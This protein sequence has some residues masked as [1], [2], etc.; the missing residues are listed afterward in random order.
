MNR[1]LPVAPILAVVTTITLQSQPVFALERS[2]I[3]AKAKE[4]TVLINGEATGTG[5]I[6]DNEGNTYT[7]LTCWHVVKTPGNYQVTTPDGENYQVTQIQH[8]PDLDLAVIKF[9]SSKTYQIAELGNSQTLTEGTKIYIVGYP[10]PFPGIPDRI[11]T[12]LNADVVG[13][14]A[15]GKNGYQIIHDNPST[16]G[17]SGGGIFDNNVML[18]G[19]NGQFISEGNTGKAYGQGIPVQIYL[20][21]RSNLQI[22]TNST[23]PQDFVSLGR[24]KL[25]QQDYPSAITLFNQ[26]LEK[27]AQDVNAYHSRGE[28]FFV[29]KDYEAAIK[30]FNR[31][32]ELSPNNHLVYFYRGYIRAEKGDYQ[33]AIADFN[34]AIQ[35]NPNFDLAY[36]NRGF[37]YAQLGDPQRAIADYERAIEINP[38]SATAYYNRGLVFGRELGDYEQALIDFTRSIEV[39]PEDPQ[40]YVE[41]GNVYSLLKKTELAIN[42]YNQAISL[43]PQHAEAHYNRG[44]AYSQ[45]NEP[46]KALQDLQR[47]S[48]LFQ[49]KGDN[50]NYQRAL[51]RIRELQGN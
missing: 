16:P 6:I 28:A 11:Y 34:Q 44:V 10:D 4:S 5:T 48:T 1:Y 3:A 21:T 32:L 23:P 22:P 47:A 19:I 8:I 42:D 49:E 43:N 30:D 37:A 2:E 45:Q 50:A 14:L 26:A 7:I 17:G 27:D 15:T 24:Q 39:V 46:E 13:K 35:V 25:K 51:D 33:D 41:R 36:T 18:V 31:F 12:F 9:T 38:E 40:V 29:L 20:A